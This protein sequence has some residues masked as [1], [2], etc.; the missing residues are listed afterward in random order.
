MKLI[1]KQIVEATKPTIYIGRRT[2]KSK[3]TGE[4]CTVKP[5]WA[6]YFT[7]GKQYQEPLGT[8]NKNAAIRAAYALSDR[9]ERGQ[10]KIRDSRKTVQE[11]ADRYHLYC[12]ALNLAKKTLV[13]Y[14]G[15]L[16][17]FKKWCESE[18]VRRARTFCP[19]DL[20][21]YRTYLVEQCNLSQKSVYN[22]TIVIKQLFKW[23]AKNGYLSRNLLEPIRFEKV[24]SPKQP[25][26]TIEQVEMLLSSAERWAVPMFATLAFTGIR[27]GELQQLRWEDADFDR[28]VIHV[29]RG[30]SGGRPKDKKDRFIPIH[31]NKLRPIL[32]SLPRK[33]ELVFLMPDDRE[34]S[35]KKLLAYLKVL[36]RQCGF[37]NPWQ[38]KLHTF[39]H[40]F[41]SYCAQQALSYKYVL[42][43][44]GHS[45]S[46]ILDMYFTMNDRHSQ[47]AMNS[48][49]FS[50]ESAENRTIIG[51]SGT[52]LQKALPQAIQV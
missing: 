19:D 12:K 3:R 24:K 9:L 43:W 4:I 48:L 20:F 30:G 5:Y 41:A 13:K 50:G 33:S 42:E 34:V 52:L 38:Y 25:C 27:I 16:D 11:L 35:E 29:H 28:N 36:C 18:G 21:A 8:S 45:C 46:A 6:E 15:Q 40:F 39:R 14:K 37:Q 23:A 7:N 10:Q 51:Q 44:M 49:S 17:R 22:E 32:Q 26:F 1:D 2:Y 31:V 47:N